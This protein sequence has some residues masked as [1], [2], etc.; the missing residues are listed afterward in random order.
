MK[1]RRDNRMRSVRLKFK[2]GFVVERGFPNTIG[3]IGELEIKGNIQNKIL[4]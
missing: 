2:E 1:K 3:R 4:L